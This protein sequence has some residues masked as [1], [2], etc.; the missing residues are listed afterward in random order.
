MFLR[1]RGLWW[2]RMMNFLMY[3]CC[4]CTDMR[5]GLET[6]ATLKKV[7]DDNE[8]IPEF[9]Q[10]AFS[11]AFALRSWIECDRNISILHLQPMCHRTY[12]GVYVYDT[13]F[14]H[15]EMVFCYI[16]VYVMLKC[17]VMTVQ[18]QGLTMFMQCANVWNRVEF[19][20]GNSGHS[21]TIWESG[22]GQFR[23]RPPMAPVAIS[24]SLSAFVPGGNVN[25]WSEQV[26]VRVHDSLIISI[27]KIVFSG[28]CPTWLIS[29]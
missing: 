5:V 22:T 26:H 2:Y 24:S 16:S 12:S 14:L 9:F 6:A 29:R 10:V 23:S 13:K 27:I 18:N 20:R 21:G 17:V 1:T 28:I 8:Q 15:H 11:C 3:S 7:F 25:Y 4:S 19:C